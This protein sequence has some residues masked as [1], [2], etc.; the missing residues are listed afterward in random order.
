MIGMRI[1][2]EASKLEINILRRSNSETEDYGDG[3]WLEF[4][5]Q[6]LI[7]YMVLTYM[8]TIFKNST[9]ILSLSIIVRKKK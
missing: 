6:D 3:N 5:F 7:V 4:K 9:R 2:N 8:L 1:K